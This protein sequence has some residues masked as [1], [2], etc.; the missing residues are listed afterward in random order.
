MQKERVESWITC[1]GKIQ[2]GSVLSQ[3][4]RE[5]T[6]S[7]PKGRIIF[8]I[9]KHSQCHNFIHNFSLIE[10]GFEGRSGGGGDISQS[11]MGN[12][13]ANDDSKIPW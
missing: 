5:V 1:H 11:M 7:F 12:D 9:P 4:F 10:I 3:S 2:S 8:R 13:K 6:N